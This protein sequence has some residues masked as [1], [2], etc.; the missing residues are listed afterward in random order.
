MAKTGNEQAINALQSV[1]S[2]RNQGRDQAINALQ[3]LAKKGTEH[4]IKLLAV[5]NLDTAFEPNPEYCW[6]FVEDSA[7]GLDVVGAAQACGILVKAVEH[8]RGKKQ[9][10]AGRDARN[11]LQCNA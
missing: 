7:V 9:V 4:A 2:L 1:A 11:F 5:T 8:S 6:S 10:A 3:S